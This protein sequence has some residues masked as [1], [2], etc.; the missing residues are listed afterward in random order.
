MYNNAYGIGSN[1]TILVSK[2]Q[3][4][5][6]F[7]FNTH[8]FVFCWIAKKAWLCIPNVC[9][10]YK[11]PYEIKTQRYQNSRTRSITIISLWESILQARLKLHVGL[12]FARRRPKQRSSRI[13]SAVPTW[14]GASRARDQEVS[15]QQELQQFPGNTLLFPGSCIRRHP[16]RFITPVSLLDQVQWN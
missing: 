14:A 11:I 10:A 2:V 6:N 16:D 4:V 3:I 15:T 7:L 9:P 8:F 5:F 12:P 13:T 1:R